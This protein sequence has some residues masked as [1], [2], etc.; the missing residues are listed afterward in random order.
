MTIRTPE[1]PTTPIWLQERLRLQG[2]L[3]HQAHQQVNGHL[4]HQGL[5]GCSQQLGHLHVARALKDVKDTYDTKSYNAKDT[6]PRAPIIV[7]T[8]IDA[9]KGSEDTR[10]TM[11]CL[12]RAPSIIKTPMTP[13]IQSAKRLALNQP[14]WR[15][16]PF[17]PWWPFSTIT[18]RR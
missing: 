9:I 2:H 7:R 11:L 4:R 1:T 3:W 16:D 10:D 8:P 18:T 13:I 15:R 12:V 14:E 5:R 17:Y 6:S